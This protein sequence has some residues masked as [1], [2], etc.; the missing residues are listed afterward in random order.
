VVV[1]LLVPTDLEI[2]DD[3]DDD[4]EAAADRTFDSSRRLI[5]SAISN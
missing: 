3:D 5:L 4:D 1:I 2:A